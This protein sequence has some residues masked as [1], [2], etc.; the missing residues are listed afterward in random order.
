MAR[1]RIRRGGRRRRLY[2]RRGRKPSKAGLLRF[3]PKLSLRAL[4][5]QKAQRKFPNLN[6]LNSYW[7]ASDGQFSWYEV[8]M[9]DPNAPEI[10]ADPQLKWLTLPR[11]RKRALRGLTRVGKRARGLK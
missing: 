4:A 6:V 11:H 10:R 7:V 8:I 2:G 5:E 3:T 9:V 1:V